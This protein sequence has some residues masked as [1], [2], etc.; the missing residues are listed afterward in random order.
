MWRISDMWRILD[1]FTLILSKCQNVHL[2]VVYFCIISAPKL[3]LL[4]YQKSHI[5]QTKDYIFFIWLKNWS[6]PVAPEQVKSESESWGFYDPFN[7][8]GH[9]GTGPRIQTK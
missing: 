1:F 8:Q 6:T 3:I 2:L 5:L 4:L 7:S 9:I